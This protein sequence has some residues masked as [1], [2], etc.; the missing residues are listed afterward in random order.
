[1]ILDGIGASSGVAIGKVFIKKQGTSKVPNTKI[2]NVEAEIK[3]FEEAKEEALKELQVL[4]TKAVEEVGE[5]HA[6]IFDVHQMLVQDLD[7]NDQVVNFITE[8]KYNAAYAVSEAAVIIAAMFES[9]DD[10]YLQERAADIRDISKR[11]IGI[12]TGEKEVSLADLQEPVI[13]VAKDLFPSDTIQMNKKFVLGFI[14]EDGGKMSHSAI[15]A[16]TMQIP[17]V[18]GLENALTKFNNDDI[19]ILDGKNGKV[20]TEPTE[21]MVAEWTLEQEKYRNYKEELQK[22]IGTPNV[23]IDGVHIEVNA[24]IGSPDD[25]ENVLA[26]DAKGVGLFRSEFLYMDGKALPTEEMQY[27]A[28]K[29]VLEAMEDR[30][31]IRTLDVGGDKELPYLNIPKEENPF[32]GYRAIRVCLDQPELFKTQL[33]ALLRASVHGKLGIMFPMIATVNEIKAARKVLEETKQE[34]LAEGIAVSEDIEVGMMIET[35]AAALVSDL[36]AKEVDFFSIGTNDLTQYTMAVDRMNAKIAHLYD[37]HNLAILRSIKM[38]ADNA[39]K[40]GIW[41][42][43]CGESAADTTLTETYLAMGIDELSV[44]AP[45]VLEVRKKIQQVDTQ[46]AKASLNL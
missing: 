7:L 28:Y 12:L 20:Y 22:L 2:E 10:P 14:T 11:L 40:A 34:L 23:T 29:K 4:Y 31:I 33:R 42:G 37:T 1:M 45:S 30:V 8:D 27:E 41:V 39:H 16:R 38:V 44:S 6:G 46:K 5:E 18:V 3:R 13:L 21:E 32:L 26:N 35:P 17:A 25:I 36:L 24:N 15:L 9:M 19:I 43:I